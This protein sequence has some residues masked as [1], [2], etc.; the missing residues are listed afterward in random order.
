MTWRGTQRHVANLV[1]RDFV[2]ENQGRAVPGVLWGPAG[3]A[4][5]RLVLLG[6]G[7]TVHKKADYVRLV[8][9]GLAGFGI[10]SMAIDGPGHG[11]RPG[12]TGST[13]FTEAKFASAWESDGGTDAMVSDWIAAL[14]FIEAEQGARSVG[15]WGLSMG[16]MMG[17]P[18]IAQ[19]S[20]LK[21][22]VLGLM[23]IRGPNGVD[24]LRLAPEVSCPVRF[25][26]QLDDE[27]VPK[28]AVR[29]LFDAIGSEDKA[30]YAN[31]GRHAGVP[32]AESLATLKFLDE[33]L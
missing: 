5:N 31:P 24:L 22:A 7:G 4:A 19:E 33:R 29:A 8:A 9:M 11:D 1:E 21:V 27:V 6:H 32:V 17:L 18:V 25:L 13:A 26:L 12:A 20:R 10:A 2:L 16:T 28:V 23:G 14:D 15:W 3:S 30:L